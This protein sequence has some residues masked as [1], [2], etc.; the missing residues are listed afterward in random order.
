MA[1]PQ[2]FTLVSPYPVLSLEWRQQ[3]ESTKFQAQY[4]EQM[5]KQVH[6]HSQFLQKVVGFVY[7]RAVVYARWE[8]ATAEVP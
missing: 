2:A 5:E 6:C 7:G 3:E 1:A 8:W 4:R